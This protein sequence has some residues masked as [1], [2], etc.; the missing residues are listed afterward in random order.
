MN[1]KTWTLLL[2][3]LVAGSATAYG[4][5]SIFFVEKTPAQE[6]KAFGSGVKERL[7]V[8]K[9]AVAAG[10]VLTA[11]NTRF[12]LVD[13]NDAPR[14]GVVSFNGV[15]G[16]VV[17][18]DLKDGETISLYDLENPAMSEVSSAGFVPPGYSIVS[19][20]IAAASKENGSRNY[21]RT[22]KL[23][24]IVRV[25]DVVDVSVV[26][27]ES[28]KT[29]G[30]VVRRLV[31][32]SIASEV[33]VFAVADEER[34]GSEGSERVSTLS[35]LLTNE[36]LEKTR[37]AFE[38]GKLKI[39]LNNASDADVDLDGADVYSNRIGVGSRKGEPSFATV[40]EGFVIKNLESED[41]SE[42]LSADEP[43]EVESDDES[44][45]IS[46]NDGFEI[47]FPQ[48][49]AESGSDASMPRVEDVQ[50]D[51][52]E[53]APDVDVTQEA[54][55]WNNVSFAG[56]ELESSNELQNNPGGNYNGDQNWIGERTYRSR[57]TQTE[58]VD[59]YV[60]SNPDLPV[61]DS[62]QPV[63]E[64]SLVNARNDLQKDFKKKSPFVTVPVKKKN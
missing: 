23:D 62:A 45:L 59:S 35:L 31:T 4:I 26:K 17:V 25:G 40:N 33:E 22:T 16:R 57:P 12:V 53:T 24:H 9:G 56:S 61:A 18:R 51:A 10:S 14:D 41:D 48:T 54:P 3:A 37:R 49:D 6:E 28:D 58:T 46:G 64:S 30:R 44:T 15:S 8:A 27:E 63:S 2:V 55:K 1:W 52:P 19:V 32:E 42:T 21:L 5:K 38:Q 43:V 39:S 20:E 36:Q 60:V 34:F 11:Q 7:L 13:E 50:S 47:S 29:D